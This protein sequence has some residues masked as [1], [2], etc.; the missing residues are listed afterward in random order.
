MICFPLDNTEYEANA[1]GAW[2]GTRTRG[3]F[4]ADGHYSVTPNGD[5][6]VT[7]SPG[8]AWLK[9]G[10]Y[11]GV[12]AYEI[13]S[14]L[15]TIATADGALSRIDAVCIRLDKNRNVGEIVIKQGAYTPQ[16]PTIAAPVRNLDYDEIYVATIMVRAGATAILPTD[17]TDQRL[18][19]TYCGVMR[20][21]VTAIPTQEL[22][23]AWWAWFSSLQI[24]T[25]Q[26]AAAFIA[27]M[28]AFK[29]E[30]E[31]GLAAWLADFKNT[32]QAD[33]DLWFTA[34]KSGNITAY[35]GWYDAFK[36]NSET[37]F[38]AWFQNLQNQLDDNQAANLQNQI[39]QHK[40]TEAAGADGV[41]G[42]RYKNG[43]LQI[44]L[45]DGWATLAEVVYGLRS[46]Y[47]DALGK[48]SI[49]IDAL[50]YTATQINNLIEMEV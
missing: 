42:V 45:A 22:Y 12:N 50:L 14:Q 38:N 19:E 32:S 27:W 16:P 20:D 37:N 13:N 49:E 47:I 5:M 30:N 46:T 40:A 18:N 4:A 29:Q 34:F 7:V 31:T 39:D 24:D 28:F 26:R 6:T 35:N 3:V 48:T 43:K 10:D 17:I 41:H 25:E 1:L 33:F 36:T 15:L 8:L 2:C 21:G 11:W 23:D 44:R 9:A